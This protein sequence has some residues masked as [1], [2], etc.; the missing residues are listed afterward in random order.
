MQYEILYSIDNDTTKFQCYNLPV[1]ENKGSRKRND[2]GV[3]WFV[4]AK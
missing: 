2:K 1:L 3:I 4:T